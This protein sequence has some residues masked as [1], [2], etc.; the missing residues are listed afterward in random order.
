MD[1]ILLQVE[2][3]KNMILKS[4]EY[5]E[6]DKYKKILDNNNEI[7][8][9]INEIKIKQKEII[10]KEA[11]NIDKDKEEFEVKNL[12][13]KL[14]SYNDYNNYINAAKVL[15]SLISGIQKRFT[16]YFNEFIL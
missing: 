2:E 16:D 11:R 10:N 3:L 14:E 4:D 5:K 7:K 6:F 9:I 15:N 8:N 1:K 13:N 12:F